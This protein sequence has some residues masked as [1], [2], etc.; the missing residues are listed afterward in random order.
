MFLSYDGPCVKFSINLI[1]MESVHR[2]LTGGV[3][4]CAVYTWP[5]SC[6]LGR[7]WKKKNAATVCRCDW[8][9]TISWCH[10]SCV[11]SVHG[12][13][14]CQC[15]CVYVGWGWVFFS[16]CLPTAWKPPAESNSNYHLGGMW[17]PRVKFPLTPMEEEVRRC[18]SPWGTACS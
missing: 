4:C 16:S 18:S 17:D 12:V 14:K 1:S 8:C 3:K 9:H 6:T 15:V 11:S 10:N 7:A 5:N 13:F 2:S